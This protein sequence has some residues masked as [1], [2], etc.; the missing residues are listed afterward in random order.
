MAGKK[1]PVEDGSVSTAEKSLEVCRLV[2]DYAEQ[3]SNCSVC[4]CDMEKHGDGCPYP[5]AKEV[6]EGK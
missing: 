2:V 1:R 6:L 4:G 3:T 5:L